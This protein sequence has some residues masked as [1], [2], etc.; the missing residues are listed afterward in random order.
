MGNKPVPNQDSFLYRLCISEEPDLKKLNKE[1]IFG[2]LSSKKLPN[3]PTFKLYNG[4]SELDVSILEAEVTI[5][6]N[7]SQY[8]ILK[9]YYS[10]ILNLLKIKADLNFDNPIY[11]IL[12]VILKPEDFGIDWEYLKSMPKETNAYEYYNQY[13]ANN[14]N[15][16]KDYLWLYRKQLFSI[17]KIECKYSP[18]SKFPNE[19][20]ASNYKDYFE[21]KYQLKTQIDDQP[22][23]EVKNESIRNN[24]FLKDNFSQKK[25]K[26]NNYKIYLI[27]EHMKIIPLKKN[28]LFNYSMIP[29]ILYRID[30]LLKARKLQLSIEGVLKKRMNLEDVQNVPLSWNKSIKFNKLNQNNEIL[31]EEN[32]KINEENGKI[33]D[34]NG[35]INDVNGKINDVNEI[36]IDVNDSELTSDDESLEKLLD[37]CP[38]YKTQVVFC[39]EQDILHDR[40]ENP[41]L[42]IKKQ[43]D[44]PRFP[45]MFNILQCVT[46][47][48]AC[49]SFDLERYELLGDCFL[50]LVVVMKIYCVFPKINE[51]K[52]VSLKSARVSNNYLYRL[53]AE[54]KLNEYIIWDNFMPQ[55]NWV[56]P[57]FDKDLF[58]QNSNFNT[59]I[60]DKSMA[61]CIE[62]LIG[63]YLTYLGSDAAK[64]FIE[65]LDFKIS[66]NIGKADFT[67]ECFLP[68]PMF[69][70][71]EFTLTESQINRLKNF[72]KILGYEFTNKYYL[73][74]ALTHP[75]DISNCCTSSYQK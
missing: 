44:E 72:E 29:A 19:K 33:N 34:V 60:S 73:F 5:N 53:A 8:E 30:C 31:N 68:E 70:Q 1:R 45:N 28:L 25:E 14:L 71:S 57:N 64:A 62:A 58:L 54:K 50:K 27:M 37:P 10:S 46:L 13:K 74:Q 47:K 6:L 63:I 20:E 61:D 55:K 66:D 43:V 11:G 48:S 22:L 69:S 36:I 39:Q 15:S 75:S 2:I 42:I 12:L 16:I 4:N 38:K 24:F 52:M 26:K 7:E 65:W 23:V 18:L 40:P 67:T 35:K 32:G 49:D 59:K 3:L 21:K 9:K 41:N 17:K 56:V 51:G